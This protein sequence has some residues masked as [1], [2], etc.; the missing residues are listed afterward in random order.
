[1]VRK[2]QERIV[3]DVFL[4]LLGSD[5]SKLR[6]ETARSLT[7][8]VLNANFY[9]LCS[10]PNQNLLLSAAESFLKSDGH[11]ANLFNA[12]VIDN[13]L[14]NLHT[15][16]TIFENNRATGSLSSQPQSQPQTQQQQQHQQSTSFKTPTSLL[17][18]IGNK[19][20]IKYLCSPLSSLSLQSSIPSFSKVN[21]IVNNNFIQ[22]FY[23][24]IKHWPSNV[25]NT[26]II[27]NSLNK[28][29]E[30]NLSYII[31]VLVN[32]FVHSIDK[33]QFIGCLEAIDFL[34]Q[35]FEPAIF[36]S[37]PVSAVNTLN[38]ISLLSADVSNSNSNYQQIYDLLAMLVAY[39]KHP[40]VAFD[41]YVHDI[42]LRLVGHLLCSYTWLWMKKLDKMVDHLNI[43]V[44]NTQQQP[45]Q[46]PVIWTKE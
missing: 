21:Q 28:L 15:I 38:S 10:N 17:H 6:L 42:V 19:R 14:Y 7:R 9:E 13:D 45:Q 27:N 20:Q 18:S 8:F 26:N 32:N 3:E 39:L 35:T 40:T 12:S 25:S 11:A 4:Y 30:Q 37:S 43:F 46:L 5:D 1:M 44:N 16:N 2:T 24:L 23:S 41:F 29:V 31:P 33:N 36:Y 22:P 34:F